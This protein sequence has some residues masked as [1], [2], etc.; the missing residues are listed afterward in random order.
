MSRKEINSLRKKLNAKEEEYLKLKQEY[1]DA[2]EKL[3]EKKDKKEET[4]ESWL[5]YLNGFFSAMNNKKRLLIQSGN[6]AY[7]SLL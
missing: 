5:L 2:V 6:L 7:R 3:K 1:S 4:K